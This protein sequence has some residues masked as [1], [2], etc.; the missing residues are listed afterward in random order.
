ME[1]T[2]AGRLVDADTLAALQRAWDAALEALAA[3]AERIGPDGGGLTPSDLPLVS[4]DQ[5]DIDAFEV[6]GP[7][8]DVLPATALQAGL[9]FHTLAADE[10]DT[11]V[12][13]V[14]AAL[15][16]TGELDETRL[17]AAARELLRRQPALRMHLSTTASGEV[18]QV[19]PADAEPDWQ[20]AD[21]DPADIEAARAAE[22]ARPFD[23]ETPPLIRFRLFRTGPGEHRLLITNHHALLDGWSMPLVGR[24]LLGLYRELGG[25][26]AVPSS[27]SPQ[28]YHRWLAARDR[29]AALEAWRAALSGVDEGTR[30]APVAARRG[31][32]RPGSVRVE[33]GEDFTA[34]LQTFARE[35][36]VTVTTVLQAA[37]GL[38]LGRLTRRRDV[39]F[40]CPVSGRPA[41]VDGVE[42]MIGQLGNTIPVRVRYRP[43]QSAASLLAE[44]HDESVA[45]T[46][47]HHL[48]LPDIQRTIGVGEL[49]DTMLVM[50]NFP[51]NGAGIV[52]DERAALS[53][54]DITDATHYPLT[55]IALPGEALTLVLSYQPQAF[56]DDTV[57]GYAR[58]LHTLLA[59]LVADADRPVGR[60]PML[61][62]DETAEI[63]HQGTKYL[64]AVPREGVLET[65]AGWVARQP[66]AEALVC[67]DRSLTYA[68]LDRQ[69]NQLARR[70]LAS[71]VGPETPVG[72]LLGRDVEMIIALFGILKAGA[73]Y[74]PLDPDYPNDRLAYMISDARPAAFVTDAAALAKLGGAVPG[75][76]AVVRID[77]PDVLHGSTGTDTDP[78]AD[79]DPVEARATLTADSLA[80]IIYTSGTTGKPKGVAVPHRGVPDLI[81][82]QEEVVG[83]TSGDRYLHFASTSFDVAFWQTMVPLASGGTLVVAPEEVRVPGDELLD[84]IER[85]RLTGINLLPSFLSAVPEDRIVDPGVFFVVGAERLDPELADRW[86]K[87]RRALFN[88]YGPTEVT[89]NSVTWHYEPGERGAVPIGR[90]DPNVRAYV[91]DD[92]LQPVGTGVPGELYLA[93]P[94]LARGYLGRPGQTAQAFVADP[95]GEPGS[96][97]Y[98]TGDVAAWRPDG[99]LVFLGRADRQVKVRGFRIELAEIES[100]LTR[101]PDVRGCA[102]VVRDGRQLVGYV[103][104]AEGDTV[105][106]VRLRA[107]L[108]AELPE[109]MVPTAFVALD[110]L[111]LTP[112]GKLDERALPA[113][114][115]GEDGEGRA[116][117]THAEQALLDIVRDVLGSDDIRLDDHFL[118]VGG[119]SIV[120]LQVVSRARRQ[121]LRLGPRDVLDGGTVAGIAARCTTA[122]AV[123]VDIGPSTGDAPLTPVMRD[124][125]ERSPRPDD[126]C[127][128]TEICV[129]AGGGKDDWTRAVD[130]LLRTH[131]VLRAHL[132][133]SADGTAVLRIPEAGA[134]TASDV[135]TVTEV[136]AGGDVRELIDG[137]IADVRSRFDVTTAPLVR[138]LWVDRGP[139][140][141]GRFVLVAHH[142]LVD[143]VSW[144]VLVDDLADAYAGRDLPRP[145]PFLGWARE[146][147]GAAAARAGETEHWRAVGQQPPK[148][149]SRT[150]F[151]SA[152]DLGSTAVHHEFA[153]DPE[154]TTAVL[155]T[156][157]SAYHGTPDTVLLTALARAVGRWRKRPAD[158]YVALEGHGRHAPDP[159]REVDLS[160]TVGWFTAVHPARITLPDGP[161]SAQLKDV[162]QRLHAQ[163]D[164]LGHGVLAGAGEVPYARPELS[165]NYLGQFAAA[166]ETPRAWQAPPGSAPFG[167]G[168]DEL[169]V[170]HSLMFNAMTW[171]DGEGQALHVRITWPRALFATDDIAALADTFRAE[172]VAIAGDEEALAGAGRTPSDLTLDGLTQSTVDTL[173]S[174]YRVIDVL[175]LSPL[176]ELMLRHTRQ[177]PDGGHDPY[178]VQATFSLAGHVD[179][180]ALHAAVGDLVAR[181][182]NLGAAFPAR[183]EG[184]V[185]LADAAPDVRYVD[186]SDSDAVYSSDAVDAMDAVDVVDAVDAA[187]ERVLADDLAEPFDVTAGS[188]VRAT[189]VRRA[190][191]RVEFVLTTHHLLSDGWSAPRMLGEIFTAYTARTAGAAEPLP[192]PVPFARYLSWLSARDRAADVAAWQDEL[193]SVDRYDR[194]LPEAVDS[195]EPVTFDLDAAAVRTLGAASAAR[196]L[197]VNTLVQG[198]WSAVLAARTGRKDVH[199]GAMVSGRPPEVDGVEDIIGLLA[200]T[201]PVRASASGELVAALRDLQDRQQSMVDHHTVAL[202]ALERSVGV[203]RLFDSLLVFENYPVDPDRL[204]EPAP[205]LRL[206]GM[207]FREFT[208]HPVTVTVMPEGAGW[209]GI[210]ACRPGMATDTSA[211]ALAAALQ[212]TL[213]ALPELL[214]RADSGTDV[215]ELVAVAE[216]A[217]AAQRLRA[218]PA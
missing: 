70:L 181:H 52:V 195:P 146:L 80:Y 117:E 213:G 193:A 92:G 57:A 208:H 177:V 189:V 122:D 145:T 59:E 81:S 102:V 67:R 148:R 25:G 32:T 15:T 30:L 63:L 136:G 89:I 130:A 178:T 84:Y 47:H 119:D 42:S 174:R 54:V 3:H 129:P 124:L 65:F 134:V 187:V 141:L 151:D 69:A 111:P 12:Y 61:A 218:G 180:E 85:H 216:R 198:A 56:D 7:V 108:L 35:R 167:S 212:A 161:T 203:K 140:E 142:L 153:L 165:W 58:W 131:D 77:D 8:A 176:Q 112:G 98:R 49:F 166:P 55:V 68:E 76:G 199:F 28:D 185:I 2:A 71:G 22:L 103:I 206:T 72:M 50:E 97:M 118:E 34:G 41:E 207:R 202:P 88:A 135:L 217:L 74:L 147:A 101:H 188:L 39:V 123:S 106:A 175:P 171:D 9:S 105:D 36:G 201:V 60:L 109:Y 120:S 93:G 149:M 6:H 183:I 162:K 115:H 43:E 200:N 211:S 168:G 204:A 133:R 11:D 127:Q 160:R 194:A 79:T 4:L 48:G 110:R 82:L 191:D 78:A 163:G 214:G 37:W 169:P 116:P 154:T 99:Q 26:P 205:G 24:T 190:A 121:G 10:G 86:G 137:W 46:D 100:A 91:L 96:R 31:V 143:G 114:D 197:T 16:L 29:D 152:R 17:R 53:G 170:P 209:R 125:L 73:V 186:V 13:V 51:F 1:W 23:P 5:A 210:V 156:V 179:V 113:P 40:G 150:V 45:L 157:P 126:F 173:E 19:V 182:P 64:P 83:V 38:L 138:A 128:W 155:S 66:D 44:I 215:A 94:K 14:Q 62:A 192:E 95:H 21:L 132:A 104:P 18:V 27:A 87:G 158:L 196:G 144:R 33:L 107:D 75:E 139:A 184:Q 90:P 159:A 20:V 164:G 172:L